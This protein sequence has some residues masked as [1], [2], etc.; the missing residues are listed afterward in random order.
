MKIQGQVAITVIWAM[1]TI[2]FADLHDLDYLLQTLLVIMETIIKSKQ[3][4]PNTR[5]DLK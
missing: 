3:K 1:S 4:R 2:L 5:I